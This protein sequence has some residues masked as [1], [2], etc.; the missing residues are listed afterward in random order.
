MRFFLLSWSLF[1]SASIF[2]CDVCGGVSSNASIGLFASTKF[3][4]IGYKSSMRSF[5]SYLYGIRHSRE[6]L[7]TQELQFRTQ[8]HP[9]IQLIGSLPF[10]NALQL[11]DLGSD[12]V[13]GIGDPN[14]IGNFVLF[15]NRDS[16]GMS[17]N[18]LS[19]GL[20][21]KFPLGK[22]VPSSNVLKNLYPGTGSW[23]YL[24]LANYTKQFSSK[25]GWQSEAS[26][27]L[28]G[29]DKYNFR[30]GNATQI[31]SQG[32]TNRAVG[33]YRLIIATGLTFE[34]HQASRNNG[35]IDSSIT[36]SGY[37]LSAK[38]SV[39]LLTYRWLWSF[40]LQQPIKQ[41]VNSSTIFQNLSAGLSLNYLIKKSKNEK[42]TL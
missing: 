17:K 18:F 27:S 24:L 8:L 31:S 12:V 40:N 10:Q 28:K 25:W 22:N 42:V 7:F 33:S 11:R 1:L 26:Y 41:N 34:Q 36:N 3:H 5:T 9:R 35:A 39:N 32:F 30:Y 15:Q 16:L 6:Y 21:V 20:G 2:A 13:F 37:I 4:T 29:T 38:A 14:L 23:D 19:V